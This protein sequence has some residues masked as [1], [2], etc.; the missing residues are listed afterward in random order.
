MKGLEI[1][2]ERAKKLRMESTTLYLA[3]MD[4][5][6]PWSAKLFIVFIV[7][8]AF[9]PIDL[10]P[11]F[12]PVIGY[13]DDLV[14]LPLGVILAMKMIPP[15]VLAECREKAETIM[16]Q[17]ERTNWVAASVIIG[18]WILFAWLGILFFIK[19]TQK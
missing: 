2:K 4:P 3:Y 19:F 13:L 12:I 17:K 6:T 18:I 8:Y 11:D 5:C 14:L 7:G 15:Q 16:S 1:W 9:S 10:I